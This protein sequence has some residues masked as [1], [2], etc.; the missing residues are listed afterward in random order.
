MVTFL[1]TKQQMKGGRY[2]CLPLDHL[3]DG[4]CSSKL[5]EYQT[6]KEDGKDQLPH[7]NNYNKIR[8]IKKDSQNTTKEYNSHQAWNY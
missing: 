5:R 4:N 3:S 1:A 7:E 2:I 8:N 6:R